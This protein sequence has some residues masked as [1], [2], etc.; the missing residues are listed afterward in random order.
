MIDR[1]KSIFGNPIRDKDYAKAVKGAES[2]RRK[3]GDDSAAH[4]VLSAERNRVLATHGHRYVDY[5][6]I[7]SLRYYGEENRAD[8]VLFGH[9]HRP[10]LIDT[11]TMLICNPGRTS[12]PRQRDRCTTCA[13]LSVE[14]DGVMS[15]E[16]FEIYEEKPDNYAIEPYEITQEY[17]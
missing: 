16:H 15:I 3:F 8:V 1:A 10:V 6:G 4:Y 11:G 9:I 14:D 12:R 2:Y 13:V 17:Y 7:D 5:G